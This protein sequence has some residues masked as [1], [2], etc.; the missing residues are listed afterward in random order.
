MIEK[1]RWILGWVIYVVMTIIIIFEFF[2]IFFMFSNWYEILFDFK[3]ILGLISFFSMF[4]LEFLVILPIS[5][6]HNYQSSDLRNI[7][8]TSYYIK[9]T[10]KIM[11]IVISIISILSIIA[12]K[13]RY[14]GTNNELYYL[15][16]IS[17]PLSQYEILSFRWLKRHVQSG[18]G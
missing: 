14:N 1:V 3:V 15:G 12:L 7:F 9:N 11:F 4:I 8:N 2:H 16:L 13:K 10:E 17:G 18:D 5:K 6:K